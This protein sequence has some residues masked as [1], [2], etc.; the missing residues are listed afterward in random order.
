ME[1]V[2]MNEED[3]ELPWRQKQ[4]TV[5]SAGL[6][7]IQLDTDPEVE[8]PTTSVQEPGPTLSAFNDTLSGK[9]FE[10]PKTTREASKLGSR[11]SLG[12]Q[13]ST[14]N[15]EKV[16]MTPLDL[17]PQQQPVMNDNNIL[18]TVFEAVLENYRSWPI[19]N[20]EFVKDAGSVE[21]IF[22][23]RDNVRVKFGSSREIPLEEFA[24]KSPQ[25]MPMLL[26]VIEKS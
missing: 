11:S 25:R 10:G 6:E 24:M 7:G 3:F 14:G 8:V 5:G 2:L 22:D 21:I 23:G 15:Y 19:E 13:D 17:Q 12:K 4:Q 18:S 9:A 20:N 26:E 1:C 16:K